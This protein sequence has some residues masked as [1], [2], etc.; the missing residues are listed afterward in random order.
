MLVCD[1]HPELNQL[2]YVECD[3]VANQEKISWL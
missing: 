2:P 3:P 1:L